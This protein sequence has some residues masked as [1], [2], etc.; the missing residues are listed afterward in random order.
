MKRKNSVNRRVSL[1]SSSS[2]NVIVVT[3]FC[4]AA[5]MGGKREQEHHAT[6]PR[7]VSK[8]E[9]HV[10]GLN[11]INADNKSQ[12]SHLHRWLLKIQESKNL[13][14]FRIIFFIE[15]RLTLQRKKSVCEILVL[16]FLCFDPF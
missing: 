15:I 14:L 9:A 3:V 13:N 8:V 7:L 16:F 1:I 10:W 5:M 2:G 11:V 12:I 6:L 4:S